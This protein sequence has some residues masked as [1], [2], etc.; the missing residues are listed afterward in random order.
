MSPNLV[1]ASHCNIKSLIVQI[2]RKIPWRIKYLLSM[3]QTQLAEGSSIRPTSARLHYD[4]IRL[5]FD[6]TCPRSTHL[7]RTIQSEKSHW[8]M[9]YLRC[10]LLSTFIICSL[11]AI[12][13][14]CLNC[15]FHKVNLPAPLLHHLLAHIVHIESVRKQPFQNMS[16]YEHHSNIWGTKQ[17]L[18]G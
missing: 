4:A 18:L 12:P 8:G 11:C 9:Q 17:V 1:L 15:L 10:T 6:S 7:Y 13:R 3:V 5:S 2:Q 14:K 16:G